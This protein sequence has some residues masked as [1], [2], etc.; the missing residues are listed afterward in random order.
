MEIQEGDCTEVAKDFKENGGIIN[1]VDGYIFL[2]EVDSGS[3]F[4]H[5]MH[6][7]KVN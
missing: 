2:I 3:F 6:V 5:R 4:I 1:E 7:K